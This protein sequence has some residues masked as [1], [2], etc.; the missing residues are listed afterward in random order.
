MGVLRFLPGFESEIDYRNA[1]LNILND[2]KQFD[3]A[4]LNRDAFTERIDWWTSY[5]SHENLVVRHISKYWLR[6][7]R[8]ELYLKKHLISKL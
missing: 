7:I 8:K 5:V 2:P 6:L 1:I 4:E 3:Y